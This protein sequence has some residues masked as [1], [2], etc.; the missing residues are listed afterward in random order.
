VSY[1][2]PQRQSIAA[3]AAGHSLLI[4]VGMIGV[5]LLGFWKLQVIDADSTVRWPS[6]TACAT[7]RDCPRGRMLDAKAVCS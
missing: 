5:L 1:W 3:G 7:F 4:I 6:A 2:F